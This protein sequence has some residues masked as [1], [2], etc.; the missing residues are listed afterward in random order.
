ML[1]CSCH[2]PPYSRLPLAVHCP[3]DRCSF[4]L[5]GSHTS[6]CTSCTHQHGSESIC[7]CQNDELEGRQPH[8]ASEVVW[9]TPPCCRLCNFQPPRLGVQESPRLYMNDDTLTCQGTLAL[10][11]SRYPE[12]GERRNHHALIMY[13]DDA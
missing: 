1:T 11:S 3:L 4:S 13:R 12:C 9:R 5:I 8:T 6:A 2:H 7:R 10:T